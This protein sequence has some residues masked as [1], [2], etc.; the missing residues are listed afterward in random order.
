MTPYVLEFVGLS[1]KPHYRESH[2]ESAL[3]DHRQSFLL[4]LGAGFCFEARQKRITVGNEHD[5]IDRGCRAPFSGDACA[6]QI[7]DGDGPWGTP[8]A[9]STGS[10]PSIPSDRDER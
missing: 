1:E 10:V 7:Q 5:Y 3:L 6:W 2:L 8:G 9:S 4:E